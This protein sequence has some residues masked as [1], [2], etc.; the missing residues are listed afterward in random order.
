MA[1]A[2]NT[3]MVIDGLVLSL[4]AANPKSYPGTGTTWFDLSRNNVDG[5]LTNGPTYNTSNGGSIL[6]DNTNDVVVVPHS[7][8]HLVTNGT[9]IFWAK[10]IS[11]G[12][13]NVCRFALKG[14]SSVGANGYNIAINTDKLLLR[15]NGGTL[16][17]V[18][19]LI[20]LYGTWQQ[21]AFAWNSSNQGTIYIN[22]TV[23]VTGS[24]GATVTM[25]STDSLYIGNITDLSR[26]FD[27][28]ISI[29]QLYNRELSA[30]EIRRNFNAVRGRYGV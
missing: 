18:T 6:F 13:A 22:D 20:P 4:D 23:D 11:D 9:M 14:S 5:T 3:S 26:T 8:A 16:T 15:V 1:I 19:S 28:N 17:G 21:Y 2:Y 30:A 25:T 29:V 27:G 10:P 24:L 12:T 7:A